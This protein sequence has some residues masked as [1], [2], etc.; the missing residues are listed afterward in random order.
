MHFNLLDIV[1]LLI[2]VILVFRGIQKGFLR[3]VFSAL[4]LIAAFMGA[5]YL[6]NDIEE[7]LKEFLKFEYLNFVSYGIAFVVIYCGVALAGYSLRRALNF[8]FFGSLDRILG[9]VLG[10]LKAVLVVSF[11]LIL[12]TAF[13]DKDSQIIRKSG[14]A[15]YG[16]MVSN[17]IVKM[18]PDKFRQQFQEGMDATRQYR[19]MMEK[20]LD[21]LKEL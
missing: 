21:K 17:Q 5:S 4:A 7:L 8:G 15:K 19:N 13:L 3:D 18:L 10:G 11:L 6:S 20:N 14:L 2:L 16:L 9:A 1:I 12:L